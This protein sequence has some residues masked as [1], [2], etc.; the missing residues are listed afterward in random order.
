MAT[1]PQTRAR[2]HAVAEGRARPASTNLCTQAPCAAGDLLLAVTFQAS[3]SSPRAKMA[4][5][6]PSRKRPATSDPPPPVAQT[7]DS[8]STRLSAKSLKVLRHFVLKVSRKPQKPVPHAPVHPNCPPP[9]TPVP[10]AGGCKQSSAAEWHEL[11][12]NIKQSARRAASSTADEPCEPRPEPRPDQRPPRPEPQAAPHAA[13]HPALYAAPVCPLG[14]CCGAT[15][16]FSRL[17]ALKEMSRADASKMYA[18]QFDGPRPN[19]EPRVF[20]HGNMEVEHGAEGL[21]S[22]VRIDTI[23]GAGDLA[24]ALVEGAQ[25]R[26]QPALKEPLRTIKRDSIPRAWWLQG[27]VGTTFT[28]AEGLPPAGS[29]QPVLTVRGRSNCLDGCPCVEGDA[30]ASACSCPSLAAQRSQPLLESNDPSRS[31]AFDGVRPPQP[32]SKLAQSAAALVKALSLQPL[33]DADAPCG[34]G[35]GNATLLERVLAFSDPEGRDSPCLLNRHRDNSRY[36]RMLPDMTAVVT[37]IGVRERDGSYRTRLTP[38][39]EAEANQSSLPGL[40]L[41]RAAIDGGEEGPTLRPKH[42]AVYVLS[43]E[44]NA[45]LVHDVV[46]GSGARDSSSAEPAKFVRFAVI[47]WASPPPLDSVHLPRLLSPVRRVQGRRRGGLLEATRG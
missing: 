30:P 11:L 7:W 29:F 32:D 46:A 18:A 25:D 44:A 4:S 38:A 24:E 31:P 2:L 3:L 13:P 47:M 34:T 17:P 5:H 40:R 36:D 12:T 15:S 37:V 21:A 39:E 23:L 33:E 19:N 14:A 10:V 45:Q 16:P 41:S 43:G 35:A 22:I 42:E 8:E 9:R 27:L 1:P 28:A 26:I 20:V 6:G